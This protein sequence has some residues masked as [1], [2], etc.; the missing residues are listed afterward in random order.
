MPLVLI[1][2]AHLF[3][4]FIIQNDWMAKGKKVSSAICLL[5]VATY[6]LPFLV[7]CSL[8][9]W[10]L[11]LIGAQHFIQDRTMVIDWFLNSTG[12]GEFAKPPMAPWSSILTDNIFHLAWIVFIIELGA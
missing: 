1:F 10:Q 5:H 7:C 12:K 11:L 6:L 3:G 2:M 8:I 4:D 9:W